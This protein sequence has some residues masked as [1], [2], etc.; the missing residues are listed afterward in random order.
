M[1]CL[2][3]TDV[4]GKHFRLAEVLYYKVLE[5]VIEQE[6]RRL[7]DADLTVRKFSRVVLSKLL[8][9]FFVQNEH[10]SD[11]YPGL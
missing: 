10:N 9:F 1:V 5:S 11:F 4:V 7:G 6:K 2:I 3:I 8:N